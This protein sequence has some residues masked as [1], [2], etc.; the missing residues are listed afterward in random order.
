MTLSNIKILPKIVFCFALVALTVAFANWSGW[1]NARQSEA[2]TTELLERDVVALTENVRANIS[3]VAFATLSYRYFAATTNE[4]KTAIEEQINTNAKTYQAFSDHA[5]A[6]ADEAFVPRLERQ[7]EIFTGLQGDFATLKQTLRFNDEGN[8]RKLLAKI[9]TEV[10]QLRADTRALTDDLIANVKR[11]SEESAQT[12]SNLIRNTL[13]ISVVMLA[14]VMGFAYAVVQGGA[15]GP[16]T[17]IAAVME[18][19]ARGDYTVEIVGAQRGDEVGMMARCAEVFK[20]NGLDAIALRRHQEDERLKAEAEAKKAEA[21]AI[22]RERELVSYSIGTA[23]TKLAEKDLTYRI[24]DKLPEAYTQLQIEFNSAMNQLEGVMRSVSESTHTISLGTQEIS[25]ASDDLSRRTESQAAN[26]EQTAAA[27]SEISN[28]V[29][30]AATGAVQARDVVAQAKD[31]AAK[32]GDVVKRAI[33]LM[34]AIEK[35]S[36]QITQIISVIDEIAFQTNLLA[37]NA[38]VEAAR[39]G[40]AG[41]GFAVVAQEVRALA[42]RS[43]GAAKEIK[44]LIGTAR[45]EVEKG[46]GLVAETGASLDRIIVRVT[47]INGVVDSIATAA[48][49]QAS[50]IAQINTAVDHMDQS[51]QQNAAMVEEAT[52]AT[53]S[54]AEQSD[55]LNGMISGFVTSARKMLSSVASPDRTVRQHKP[56]PMA[57]PPPARKKVASAQGRPTKSDPSDWTEF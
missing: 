42:Q 4:E 13:I 50:G 48:E 36:Q 38:G 20:K 39:A 49:E 54:L 9:D 35:S 6:V 17:R 12:S 1:S 56:A 24:S 46:V 19:L 55:E 8:S 28:K 3:V 26:L 18:R 27:V 5:K 40:D 37:L 11:K 22:E 31:E 51:T 15:V 44:E 57:P 41:R 43:A 30:Q 23:I 2:L 16:L 45:T 33:E 29:R 52:A 21:H 47:Q 25:S 34:A 32:S 53:K 10:E 14:I 7:K